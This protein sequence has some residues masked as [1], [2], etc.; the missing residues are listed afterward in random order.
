M[1]NE[2]VIALPTA[3]LTPSVLLHSLLEDVDEGGKL[4]VVVITADGGLVPT[5][6]AGTQSGDISNAALLLQEEIQS[7]MRACVE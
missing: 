6:S 2:K 7:R 5:W 3:R 1:S 4:I